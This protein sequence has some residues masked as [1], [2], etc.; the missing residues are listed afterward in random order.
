MQLLV[1]QV[2]QNYHSSSSSRVRQALQVL[3]Q[4]VGFPADL[5]Q[6]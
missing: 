3:Q 4:K 6:G 5:N 1:V 2:F